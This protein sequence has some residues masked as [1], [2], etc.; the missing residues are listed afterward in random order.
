L[1]A[2]AAAGPSRDRQTTDASVDDWRLWWNDTG[3]ALELRDG[4]WAWRAR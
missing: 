2:G 3:R 4:R 1:A